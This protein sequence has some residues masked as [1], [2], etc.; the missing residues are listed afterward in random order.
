MGTD[1][2][3]EI[4]NNYLEAAAENILFGGAGSFLKLVPT[5]CV[6]RG[7][8]LNKPLNWREENWEVKNLFEIKNGKNIR[9]E[10]NLMTN[11][12]TMAHRRSRYTFQRENCSEDFSDK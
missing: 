6:V 8:H 9:V 5:N 10:N 12:W 7:N 11:N 4:I 2:P 1:G 3:V